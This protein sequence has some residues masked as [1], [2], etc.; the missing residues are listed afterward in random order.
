MGDGVMAVFASAVDALTCAVAM[1]QG[2][3]RQRRDEVGLLEI[4]VGLALGEVTFE[5]GDV[6][7]TP[8]VEAARLVA[9]ATGGQ[10]LATGLVKAV[11]GTLSPA[12]FLDLGA[13]RP[14]GVTRAHPHLRGGV[15]PAHG[16][17]LRPPALARP[18]RPVV[19]RGAG[20]RVR[21]SGIVWKEAAGGKRA[22]A[23]LGGE[24]GVGKT[25]LAVELARAVHANGALV[26]AGRCDE[27]LAVPYQPFAEALRD[28][29]DCDAAGGGPPPASAVT[30]GTSPASYPRWRNGSP[31]SRR[32]G[33]PTRTPSASASSKRW[34][35]GWR[36]RP[37]PKRPSSSW[38]TTSTGRPSRRCSCCA[39]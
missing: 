37:R 8:V 10:I 25:R 3:D 2:V 35:P 7:G 20:R 1:Q 13:A 5:D 28:F 33:G 29:V 32:R 18:G 11:V 19:V 26:L 24:P 38:S 34:R 16:P 14:R 15:G 36:R 6:H 21:E 17:V 9:R 30:A 31:G 22:V 4:R 23:L 27:D 12:P 39:T